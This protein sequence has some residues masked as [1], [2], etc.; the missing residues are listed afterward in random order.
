MYVNLKR[1]IMMENNNYKKYMKIY[2][3]DR[4]SVKFGNFLLL[5]SIILF[6]FNMIICVCGDFEMLYIYV[7]GP[8]F[9]FII[10]LLLGNF[11]KPKPDDTNIFVRK[12]NH[13]YLINNNNITIPDE[14]KS[15]RRAMTYN[16]PKEISGVY[17][18]IGLIEQRKK[19]KELYKYLSQYDFNEPRYLDRIGCIIKTQIISETKTHI[20]VWLMFEKLKPKKVTIY[21]NYNDYQELVSLL[22]SMSH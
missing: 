16:A 15:A 2:G 19:I 9:L 14:L 12:D 22:K 20:K 17:S 21:N 3:E 4:F 18:F 8:I 7:F 1:V 5:F 13:L 11:F 6:I 10:G